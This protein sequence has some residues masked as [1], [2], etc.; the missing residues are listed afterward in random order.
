LTSDFSE[1]EKVKVAA[2]GAKVVAKTNPQA[3]KAKAK[4][5]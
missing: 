3:K 2:P 1:Y 4:S 5:K